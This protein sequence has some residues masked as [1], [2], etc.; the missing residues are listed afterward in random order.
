MLT[1]IDHVVIC[2]ADLPRGIETFTRLGFNVYPGGVHP[3]R[4]THNAISM[5]ADD[6][7][8]LLSRPRRRRVPRGDVALPAVRAAASSTSSPP[9]G[10][11]ATSSWP[12]TISRPTW[13]PCAAAAW[14]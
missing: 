6:Y 13:P 10:D 11:C 4:G 5:N 2:V 3:G 1:R 14:R 7:L 8:E 9:A 12:V